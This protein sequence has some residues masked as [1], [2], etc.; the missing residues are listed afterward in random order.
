MANGTYIF[1]LPGSTGACRTGWDRLIKS[2]TGLSH[3]TYSANVSTDANGHY[4][5]EDVPCCQVCDSSIWPFSGNLSF[6]FVRGSTPW[7]ANESI[8]LSCPLNGAGLN[9]TPT[10][11]A[12]AAVQPP[13]GNCQND[14]YLPTVWGALQGTYFSPAG[15]GLPIGEVVSL[16]EILIGLEGPGDS[17]LTLYTLVEGTSTDGT[18]APYGPTATPVGEGPIY[19]QWWG[20]L[21]PFYSIP[22]RNQTVIQDVGGRGT[23]SGIAYFDDGTP[24][25]GVLVYL[26]DSFGSITQ[27]TTGANGEYSFPDVPTGRVYVYGNVRGTSPYNY[28]NS[29]GYL[30][31]NGGTVIVDINSPARCNLEGTLYDYTGQPLPMAEVYLYTSNFYVGSTSAGLNGLYSFTEIQP[32]YGN[33]SSGPPCVYDGNGN[34][35]YC[36]RGDR[37]FGIGTCPSGGNPLQYDLPLYRYNQCQRPQ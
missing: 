11:A 4:R 17:N 24:A 21:D 7:T 18:T 5:I 32:D 23:V 26:L 2:A 20:W 28:T 12:L 22:Q 16:F 29:V 9:L 6:D 36:Q 37:Y 35:L 8:S 3:P 34:L 30:T 27:M 33:L 13:S 19:L 1:C 14:I 15:S 31:Q 10:P 25:A